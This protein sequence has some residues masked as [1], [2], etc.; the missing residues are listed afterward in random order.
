MTT[1]AA[2]RL[3]AD[4]GKNLTQ[5]D[6]IEN[7]CV[8]M[9]GLISGVYKDCAYFESEGY[10]FVWTKEDSFLIDQKRVG[11]YAILQYNPSIK[12][13]FNKTVL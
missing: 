10:T 9:D 11:R 4:L 5:D 7:I 13:A 1:A 8:S 12:V 2:K 3:M 6:Y